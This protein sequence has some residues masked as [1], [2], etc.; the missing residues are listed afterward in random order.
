MTIQYNFDIE[1]EYVKVLGISIGN[2]FIHQG[3]A[4]HPC[5]TERSIINPSMLE[6]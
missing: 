4:V 5:A 3:S 1:I 2:A 6:I